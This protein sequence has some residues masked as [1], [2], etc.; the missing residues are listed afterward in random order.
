M[1]YADTT[2]QL[3]GLGEARFLNAVPIYK[4]EWKRMM[5]ESIEKIIPAMYREFG[6]ALFHADSHR[7]AYP[8]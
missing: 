8:F 4:V 2:V 6:D 7:Q 3:T 1:L 5:Q